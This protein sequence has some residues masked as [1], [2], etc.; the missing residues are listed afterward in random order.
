M[1]KDPRELSDDELIDRL[2]ADEK[3]MRTARLLEENAPAD[4]EPIGDEE[5]KPRQGN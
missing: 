4:L 1:E 3:E 5:Y 2:R